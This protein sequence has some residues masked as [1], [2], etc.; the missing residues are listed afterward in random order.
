MAIKKSVKIEI[1]DKAMNNAE[2]VNDMSMLPICI[3][4][5]VLTSN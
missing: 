2:L 1:T 5:R 3:G 4:N